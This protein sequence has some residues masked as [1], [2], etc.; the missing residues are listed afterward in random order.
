MYRSPYLL[1]D[2]ILLFLLRLINW[3]CCGLWRWC[4]SHLP[5]LWRFFSSSSYQ[6]TRHCWE[7]YYQIP[8]QGKL[9]KNFLELQSLSGRYVATIQVQI[10]WSLESWK[11][12]ISGEICP[13]SSQ[14]RGEIVLVCFFRDALKQGSVGGMEF[15]VGSFPYCRMVLQN[16]L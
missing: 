3:C 11:L 5:S 2:V 1:S 10:S 14:L 8:H 12:A 7:G 13:L 16:P 15:A 6:T 4:N 9:E